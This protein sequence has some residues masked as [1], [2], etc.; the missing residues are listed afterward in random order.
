MHHEVLPVTSGYRWALTYNLALPPEFDRPSADL[1][2]DDLKSPRHALRRWLL[3]E[4]A[5]D[6]QNQEPE[7]SS[8]ECLYYLMGHQYTEAQISLKNL[9]TTD[10]ARTCALQQVS[11]ELGLEIVLAA[12][13]KEESG[14]CEHDHDRGNYNRGY[15]NKHRRGWDDESEEEEEED[16][17]DWHAMDEVFSTKYK[18]KRIVDLNGRQ[19]LSDVE[20]DEGFEERV[21]Q[22]CGPFDDTD[23][24]EEDYEGFMGNSV[25]QRHCPF[26]KRTGAY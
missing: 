12:L 24:K 7:E 1:L 25:C 14:S 13:E 15:Y 10:Y 2:R 19:L 18:F 8:L 17:A 9:K 20:T 22:Q 21:L 16:E 3:A 23:D 4:S 6:A 11:S 26:N 5:E